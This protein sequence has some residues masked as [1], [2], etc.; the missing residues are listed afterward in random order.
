MRVQSYSDT[1]NPRIMSVGIRILQ[2]RRDSVVETPRRFPGNRF[3][4]GL[5]M[6]QKRHMSLS[7]PS[8]TICD[9][10]FQAVLAT[11][12]LQT[13]FKPKRW[14]KVASSVLWIAVLLVHPFAGPYEAAARLYSLARTQMSFSQMTRDAGILTFSILSP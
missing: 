12:G 6:C 9:V 10:I 5:E 7:E 2:P 4:S 3:E 14:I 8:R 13:G 1:A 11:Y